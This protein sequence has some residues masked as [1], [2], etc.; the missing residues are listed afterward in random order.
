M[1]QMGMKFCL[2]KSSDDIKTELD[3][4]PSLQKMKN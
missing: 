2:K 1:I 3:H 4:I